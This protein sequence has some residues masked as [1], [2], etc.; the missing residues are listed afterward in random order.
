MV[1]GYYSGTGLMLRIPALSVT[2]KAPDK[3]RKARTHKLAIER[4]GCRSP[5]LRL[6]WVTVTVQNRHR[7]VHS[8]VCIIIM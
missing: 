6:P 1:F 4:L 5:P 3:I 7:N 8:G 2:V